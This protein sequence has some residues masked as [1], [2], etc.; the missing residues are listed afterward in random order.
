MTQEVD[1]LRVRH[2]SFIR[3]AFREM[4]FLH[5][6]MFNMSIYTLR[7]NFVHELTSCWEIS[8]RRQEFSPSQVVRRQS[9][10]YLPPDWCLPDVMPDSRGLL[11]L[12]PLFSTAI[13]CSI[14]PQRLP[15][16]KPSLMSGP[17]KAFRQNDQ[18]CKLEKKNQAVSCVDSRKESLTC[19][20]KHAEKKNKSQICQ[21]FFD[22]YKACI[23]RQA[24]KLK[25]DRIAARGGS[26]W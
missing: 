13:C 10:S 26:R 4:K 8:R 3:N 17:S 20:V 11:G 18:M 23:K 1:G 15:S 21:P 16:Q 22:T 12:F 19:L 9:I 7:Y 6:P 5:T 24:D 2:F 14:P 25:A